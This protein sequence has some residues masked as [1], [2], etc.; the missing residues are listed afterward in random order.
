MY[1]F[2]GRFPVDGPHHRDEVMVAAEALAHLVRYLNH[3]TRPGRAAGALPEPQD[4]ARLLGAVETALTRLP[5]LLS[6][7]SD[8]MAVLGPTVGSSD[9]AATEQVA[10]VGLWTGV[11]AGQLGEAARHVGRARAAADRL[12]VDVDE[13]VP[14][15]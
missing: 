8:R 10:A 5:P 9:G 11:A 7:L 12:Y 2:E 13:E 14:G 3:A 1:A 6:Q 15:D 4:V